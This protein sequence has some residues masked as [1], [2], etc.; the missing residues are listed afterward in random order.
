MDDSGRAPDNDSPSS[1]I[2]AKLP[3]VVDIAKDGDLVLDVTL[4]NSKETI[5]SGRAVQHRLANREPL[6]PQKRVRLAF[7]V[8]LHVLKGQSKYFEKL[9]TD[10]RFK[11]ARDISSAFAALSVKNVKPEAAEAKDLPWIKIQD[12]DQATHFAYRDGAL[13]DLFRILHGKEIATKQVTMPFVTTLAVLADRFDCAAAVSK[14]LT[15]DLKFKWPVTSRKPVRDEISVMSRNNEDTLRQK[16]LVAWLLN[17][18][19]RF[20]LATKEIIMNGSCR[21]SP[22]AEDDG[23]SDATWWFLQDGIEEELQFRRQCILNTIASVQRHFLKLYTSRTRQCKLGYDSSAACDSYQLGETF[24]FLTNKNLM[25]L[26][27]FS[28]GSLDSIADTSLLQIDTILATLRQ[29]PSYQIDKNHTNCGLRTRILPI[30]DFIQ[31]LLSANS[32]PIARLVWK[33][34]RQ[35]AAWLPPNSEGK[36]PAEAKPFSFTRSLASDQRLRFENA[37]GADKFAKDVFMASSWDWTAEDQGQD[38]L[39][40]TTP[41][42]SIK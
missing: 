16:I 25:F 18:P 14:S 1:N 26:V 32:I 2:S 42:W 11:E 3:K 27:D 10:S 23:T 34:N 35:S 6:P 13:S 38:K 36:T 29:C 30:L 28:P 31:S 4:E 15:S 17:Q 33:N 5:R 37:L 41:R 24:K 7:R 20:Q 9:L 21:W 12:D 39:P 22:F 8:S 40:S 19:H